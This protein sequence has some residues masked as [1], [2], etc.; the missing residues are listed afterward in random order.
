MSTWTHVN[1]VIRLDSMES[2]FGGVGS[3]KRKLK[4]LIGPVYL[5]YKND[6]ELNNKYWTETNK[7]DN[8]KLPCGSEGTLHVALYRNPDVHS[9]ASHTLAIFGD[10]RDFD[11]TKEIYN[12]FNQLCKDLK[13]FEKSGCMGIRSAVCEAETEFTGKI[14]LYIYNNDE[15]NSEIEVIE[16][17]TESKEI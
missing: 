2:L 16:V 6:E 13:D 9:I 14:E 12:W 8:I 3:I 17:N 5:P 15:E 4:D 10:L 1:A 7:D 11:S